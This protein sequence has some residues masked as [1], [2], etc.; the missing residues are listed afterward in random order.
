MHFQIQNNQLNGGCRLHALKDRLIL[1][2]SHYNVD[3]VDSVVTCFHYDLRGVRYSTF[4]KLVY[5]FGFKVNCFPRDINSY[6]THGLD[7]L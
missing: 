7:D 1:K 3:R 2:R 6:C 4:Y 5:C